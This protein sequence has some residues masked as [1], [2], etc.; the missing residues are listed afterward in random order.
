MPVLHFPAGVAGGMDG[1]LEVALE[2]LQRW[3]LLLP[4]AANFPELVKEAAL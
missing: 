3:Q 1:D 2:G 4:L